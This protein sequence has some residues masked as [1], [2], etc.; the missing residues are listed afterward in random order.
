[1][2][3]RVATPVMDEIDPTGWLIDS[4][5][6]DILL[7]STVYIK[8]MAMFCYCYVHGKLDE[9]A[10]IYK[11]GVKDEYKVRVKPTTNGEVIVHRSLARM[12]CRELD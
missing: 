8:Y 5:L 10:V 1:M 9:T 7:L 2:K 11:R 4:S 6:S 12:L 3:A